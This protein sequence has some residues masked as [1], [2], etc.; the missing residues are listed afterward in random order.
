MDPRSAA[1]LF[2]ARLL[3]VS[4]WEAMPL[5]L[6]AQRVQVTVREAPEGELLTR[7]FTYRQLHRTR[8]T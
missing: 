5:T 1:R 7:L 6:A 8:G 4:G 2:Y 3:A